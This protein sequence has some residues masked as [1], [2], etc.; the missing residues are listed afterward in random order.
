MCEDSLM[1]RLARQIEIH[2][3]DNEKIIQNS[4]FYKTLNLGLPI[5]LILIL[6]FIVNY[7]RKKKYAL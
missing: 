2:A 7:L 5:L 4:G 6:A 1:Y 3:M